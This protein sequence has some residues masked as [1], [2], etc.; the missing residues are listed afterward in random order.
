MIAAPSTI[1]GSTV[2]IAALRG[3]GANGT[4]GGGENDV[5][6]VRA[7]NAGL[8]TT[9]VSNID[10]VRFADPQTG[11]IDKAIAFNSI[12]TA[13]S[14]SDTL[15]VT[16][17]ISNT[18]NSIIITRAGTSGVNVDL[19]GWQF[20]NFSR[21]NQ[22]VSVALTDIFGNEPLV[23][24]QVIGTSRIDFISTGR[25]N[26]TLRGGTRRGLAGRWH[27]R[28]PLYLRRK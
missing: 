6:E 7:A 8:Q 9:S 17:S 20:T 1:F 13:L 22:T 24:D 25:G 5:I 4:G 10:G 11:A 15:T 28:R 27:W 16:G 23:A 18:A 21:A 2:N 12:Q 3:S 26:D 14:L 19:S